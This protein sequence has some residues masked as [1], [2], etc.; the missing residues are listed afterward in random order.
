[1]IWYVKPIARGFSRFYSGYM[2]KRQN[3][4]A[5]GENSVLWHKHF[6]QSKKI[7]DLFK[8]NKLKKFVNIFL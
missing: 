8:E 3:H 6:Y 4:L 1:M 2:S 5:K 7:L